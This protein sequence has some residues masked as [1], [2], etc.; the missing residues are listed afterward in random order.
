VSDVVIDSQGLSKRYRLGELSGPNWLRLLRRGD[1]AR[2]QQA[3]WAARDLTF[4]IRRGEAVGIIGSNGAGKST[5]LKM[6]SRVTSPTSGHARVVGRVGTILEVGT[7]FH[8]ELTGRENIYLSGA[9]LGMRHAE[10]DARFDEIV[11]FAG[12]ERFVDTP[13]KRY[14]SGMYVRLAFAVAAHL[15]P[16]IMIIDEVLAVG[17]VGFQKKCLSRMDQGV[18]GEGRTILF[19]SHNLQAIRSL[20]RRALLLEGGRLVADGAVSDVIA[21]Y[22]SGQRGAVD[23]RGRAM[24]N[25]LNRTGGR[26]RF[27]TIAV[28]NTGQG[29]QW[30]FR[31]GQTITL[32]FGYEVV[33]PVENLGFLL[34]LATAGT[35]DVVTSVKEVLLPEPGDPGRVGAF[36][37]TFPDNRLRPGEFALTACLGNADFS[38]FEDIIDSNVNLPH[39][40]VESDEEDFHRR[41][42]YFSADYSFAHG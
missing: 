22:L 38:A 12:V 14:S 17:D 9:I 36:S 6:L 20:C 11:A 31:P 5:L 28:R 4:Q 1:A 23:L 39:L 24:G 30:T 10:V 41:L 42:G 16:D 15:E 7:G 21:Q 37:V 26:A 19:V 2:E 13:V 3:V 33:E 8:P 27:T 40:S 29:E 34:T 18:H 25:R 32:D 35:G